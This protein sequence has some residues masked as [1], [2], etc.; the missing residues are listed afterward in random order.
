MIDQYCVKTDKRSGIANDP[1]RADDPEYIVKL[2]GKVIAVSL[3]TVKIVERLPTDL[4]RP[5]H[6]F[7]DSYQDLQKESE[8]HLGWQL[9]RPLGPRDEY[10]LKNLRIP[11][12]D[13]QRDFDALVSGLTKILI[14][15]LNQKELKKLISLEQEQNLT[16]DQKEMSQ[17]EYRMSRN[18]PQ[19]LWC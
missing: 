12:T 14:N 17:R 19:L 15:S 8:K 1:N 6:L 16:P 11:S 2:I 7:K 18:C 10:L 5:E 13:E 3:E 4:N 9:L